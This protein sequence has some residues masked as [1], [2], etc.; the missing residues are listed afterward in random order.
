MT[1]LLLF[2]FEQ[3]G[4]HLNVE[5]RSRA[6]KLL[7][8][9][10]SLGVAFTEGCHSA[11]LN[12]PDKI[13]D[14][15][16]Q[17]VEW[18][19]DHHH[20]STVR[21]SAYRLYYDIIPEQVDLMERMLTVRYELASLCGFQ[22]FAHRTL[23]ISMIGSPERAVEFLVSAA[24][25]LKPL[26]QREVTTLVDFKIK[27]EG[28]STDSRDLEPWDVGYYMHCMDVEKRELEKQSS[29]PLGRCMECLNVIFSSLFGLTLQAEETPVGELWCSDVVKLTVCNDNCD[30]VGTIYC[31][32]FARPGKQTQ[33]SQFTIRCG[34]QLKDGS[35]Q[36]PV[37]ALVCNFPKHTSTL[38]SV[39]QLENLF[40]EMGHALH[41][42]VGRTKYQHVSGTRCATD[43]A[44]VPSH[45]MEK[46]SRDPTI[47]DIITQDSR[48][49][50]DRRLQTVKEP[51]IALRTL[52]Q[53][54]YALTDLEVHGHRDAL[55]SKSAGQVHLDMM[56]RYW[57]AP[58]LPSENRLQRFSHLSSYG[59]KY[60]SY[61]LAR[62]IRN[63][64]WDQNFKGQPLN[65][66]S[67]D[68]MRQQFL[69]H[70]GS[71]P[72]RDILNNFLGHEPS[73]EELCDSLLEECL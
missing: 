73:I 60:Y 15:G 61:L 50:A 9:A 68:K 34:C 42:I 2:D 39:D 57:P 11:P 5:D 63:R 72:P 33:D 71:V 35:Y 52:G 7:E 53:V 22:S 66:E 58:F 18:A 45:L 48:S 26:A 65:R 51:G 59:A 17:A 6:L 14:H 38:L 27:S 30:E 49:Q 70:G 43:L 40:H 47:R 64:V 8:E 4:V 24:E 44:E 25:R 32:L 41:S 62:A 69:C 16:V 20:E 55:N 13:R 46:L 23:H 10:L 21:E 12:L 37:V 29:F 1:K 3:S 28:G 36:T 54:I 31:D 19:K 56:S 67:G